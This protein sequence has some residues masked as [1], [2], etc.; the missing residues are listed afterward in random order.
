MFSRHALLGGRRRSGGRRDDE[1]VD[2]FVDQHGAGVFLAAVAV[3]VFNFL[4]SWFTMLFL[5]HGAQEVN[6]VMDWVLQLGMWPFILIKSLGIGLCVLVL[7]AA[8][9]F[10]YARL[11]MLAIVI[12]YAA[13]LCWHLRLLQFIP[14]DSTGA[15]RR[16]PG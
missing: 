13:L 12:G 4:D 15:I 8:R 11:G 16:A 1:S 9:N 7:T 10:R 5:S 2:V 14:Q 6:P 3:L